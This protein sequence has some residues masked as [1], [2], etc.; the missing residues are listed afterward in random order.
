MDELSSVTLVA[1]R[2]EIKQLKARYFRFLDTKQ[3]AD[4]RRLFCDDCAFEGTSRA[5]EDA[6]AFV[7]GV[8]ADHARTRTVHHGHMPEIGIEDAGR[9]RGIWAM[10][11]LVTWPD[12]EPLS[13]FEAEPGDWGFRGHGHYHE[14][15]RKDD[16]VW[17]ISSLRL[18]RLWVGPLNGPRPRDLAG[19][20]PNGW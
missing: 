11:D 18:T 4:W 6:D 2:E 13:W 17:R 8:S 10:S 14:R 19:Y 9:A 7:A 5:F 3:W 20:P 1:E 15:Y 12:G 16:G